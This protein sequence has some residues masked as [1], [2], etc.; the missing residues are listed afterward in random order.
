MGFRHRDPVLTRIIKKEKTMRMTKA[1][2]A[3]IITLVLLVS[4]NALAAELKIGYANL[5]KALNECDAGV[6]A[7]EDLKA[8]AQKLEDELN[9]EQ[10][11]LKKLKDELD[12]KSAV[13]NK[14]T[15]DSKERDFRARTADFQKKF[16]E[17]GEKLN[18]RK[19]ETEANI[20][21][22]LRDVVEEIAKKKGMSF[23]FERSVGGL[24]YAPKDYDI[25]DEVIKAYNKKSGK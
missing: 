16:T 21:E 18:N 7:K 12:K 24:L 22:E 2:S 19:Q 4:G 25:T 3:V 15:K 9:K 1:I 14:E 17:Y 8:E 20:I 5:Q 11:T 23:V 6:K 13:W 10:E